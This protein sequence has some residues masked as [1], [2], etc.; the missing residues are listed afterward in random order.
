M[1]GAEALILHIFTLL[2]TVGFFPLSP[3]MDISLTELL[4]MRPCTRVY[5]LAVNGSRTS[6]VVA[7]LDC[8]TAGRTKS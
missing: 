4:D 2:Y 6:V 5:K 3:L 8:E 1:I 7:P